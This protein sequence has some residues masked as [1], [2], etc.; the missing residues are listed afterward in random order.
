MMNGNLPYVLGFQKTS[1]GDDYLAYKSQEL[2]DDVDAP[3]WNPDM[4]FHS[5]ALA[6]N[7][8][9]LH[10][11][12]VNIIFADSL[13]GIITFNI[14]DLVDACIASS[15]GTTDSNGHFGDASQYG[16]SA[17]FS[18]EDWL[19]I[20]PIQPSQDQLVDLPGKFY[21]GI[22][23]YLQKQ[24]KITTIP[25]INPPHFPKGKAST[26]KDLYDPDGL[27][28]IEILDEDEQ[29]PIPAWAGPLIQFLNTFHFDKKEENRF[30]G[31]A[32]GKVAL[33]N[34]V[35]GGLLPA[36]MEG[37]WEG[38]LTD[39]A[40]TARF[41]FINQGAN[42]VQKNLITNEY[43]VDFGF[44]DAQ[45]FEMI[46]GHHPYCGKMFF[47]PQT[48]M[49][50]RII[51]KGEVYVPPAQG[52]DLRRWEW[53]K[54]LLRSSC[55]VIN[56]VLHLTQIHQVWAN[57]PNI[58]MREHF[59]PNHPV[60]LLMS[61]FYYRSAMVARK[62]INSL[63]PNQGLL[64]R[65]LAYNDINEWQRALKV[66]F[67]VWKF[68]TFQDEIKEK[69]L[70]DDDLFPV[71]IDGI[72]LENIIYKFVSN[73]LDVFYNDTNKKVVNDKDLFDFW[74]RMQELFKRHLINPVDQ[75]LPRDF[76]LA[77]LKIVLAE[78]IFR[79]TGGHSQAG[80]AIASALDPCM[81]NLRISQ[82]TEDDDRNFVAPF[83]ASAIQC[84]VT[85]LTALPIAK[86]D[87][88]ISHFFV[89]NKKSLEVYRAF[90][91]DLAHLSTEIKK[92]N[93][94]RQWPLSDFDPNY[95]N[96]STAV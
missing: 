46:E 79:V 89:A 95:C 81:V 62:S 74:E 35:R 19:S 10:V 72:K 80:D 90:L 38:D 7:E 32:Q 41:F 76:T 31:R 36:P 69:N 5:H 88:D 56:S 64:H 63:V 22:F 52:G 1:D 84:A 55:F 23:G 48:R 18:V 20:Y 16:F 86:L 82:F 17:S 33:Q 39:D 47:D 9:E 83:E 28:Y 13:Y 40:N 49:P 94:M 51:V 59:D 54:F 71:G 15:D 66:G 11:K 50:I 44:M 34:L 96:I 53:A 42:F 29:V 93:Q 78:C 91:D 37:Q 2:H 3:R 85:A 60:R 73:Y 65:G 27:P 68:Q 30:G 12:D 77:N 25:K 14:G 61:P 70:L 4:M 43:E 8:F 87:T 6:A 21:D 26:Y 24:I 45:N 58:A 75:G 92:A 67:S 57:Y